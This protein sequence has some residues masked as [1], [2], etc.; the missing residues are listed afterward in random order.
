MQPLHPEESTFNATFGGFRSMVENTFGDLGRTFTKFNNRE[1]VRVT[2]KKE[3]N[4][5]L[6]L[7]LLLMNIRNFASALNIEMLPHH[8]AW[9]EPDFD[10]PSEKKLIPE[11][12]E[13]YTVQTKLESGAELLKLQEAF[14]GMEL[15]D[16][17]EE[18]EVLLAVEIPMAK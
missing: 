9:M 3:F 1:P 17:D 13:T 8:R 6:R 11:L 4:I 15:L 14:L 7:C 2:A 16:D 18:R 10:Y 12:T 5:S